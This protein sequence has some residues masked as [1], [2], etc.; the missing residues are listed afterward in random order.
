MTKPVPSDAACVRWTFVPD[1][2]ELVSYRMSVVNIRQQV[3]KPQIEAF[4]ETVPYHNVKKRHLYTDLY[5]PRYQAPRLISNKPA[6]VQ[7][8]VWCRTGDKPLS[9]QM[10]A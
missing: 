8:M 1:Q 6:V 7:M 4:L 9:E 10:M 2:K 5:S 3:S